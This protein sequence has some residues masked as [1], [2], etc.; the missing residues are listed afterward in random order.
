[1]VYGLTANLVVWPVV[2]RVF[3]P[4]ATWVVLALWTGPAAAGLGVGV[5]ILVSARVRGFQEAYQLGA[6]V[7]LPIVVLVVGQA[8]GLVFL[9][10]WLALGLGALFWGIDARLL[11]L[12]SRALQRDSLLLRQ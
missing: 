6:L 3:F 8:T 11:W 4:S 7:V 1:M 2:G 12:G 10:P 5:M 9:S